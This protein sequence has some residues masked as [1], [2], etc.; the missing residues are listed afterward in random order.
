M[1]KC[2]TLGDIS[3]FIHKQKVPHGMKHDYQRVG[4]ANRILAQVACVWKRHDPFSLSIL[5]KSIL[6]V[7]CHNG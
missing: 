3:L 6:P 7:V 1:L 5:T 2:A 4:L